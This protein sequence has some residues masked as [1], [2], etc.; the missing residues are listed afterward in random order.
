TNGNHPLAGQTLTFS[1][2]RST[3]A[4]VDMSDNELTAYTDQAATNSC[5]AGIARFDLY[6]ADT[7]EKLF[8]I[9]PGMVIDTDQ[10]GTTNLNIEAIATG[11]VGHLGSVV[12]D[13]DS[14]AYT[15]TEN[16]GQLFLFSDIAGVPQP[17]PGPWLDAG[18][19]TVSC[20]PYSQPN[21][22]GQAGTAFS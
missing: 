21:A 9:T 2:N 6:N 7:G 22:Q 17:D 8:E 10:L 5:P 13:I 3:G 11:G 1:Y 19:H 18:E 14:G 4:T 16:I 12:F 20:T 15:H